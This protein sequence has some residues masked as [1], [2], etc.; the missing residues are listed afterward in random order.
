MSMASILPCPNC[1]DT[2]EEKYIVGVE[3]AA[4]CN[5]CVSSTLEEQE[6]LRFAVEYPQ[7]VP[8]IVG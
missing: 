5:K 3:A 6:E 4:W 8:G 2:N 7:I 1:G